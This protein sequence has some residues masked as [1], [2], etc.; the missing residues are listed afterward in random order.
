M[1]LLTYAASHISASSVIINTGKQRSLYPC[2]KWKTS[3]QSTVLHS[4]WAMPSEMEKLINVASDI[5]LCK[6]QEELKATKNSFQNYNAWTT[7]AWLQHQIQINELRGKY[8][9]LERWLSSEGHVLPLR[10]TQVQHPAPTWYF[11]AIYNSSTKGSKTLF[12]PPWAVGTCYGQ[13]Y[14]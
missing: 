11:T 1:R 5:E 6:R 10:K 14:M 2:P 12:C 7:I 13:T 4:H 9:R 3:L 8:C